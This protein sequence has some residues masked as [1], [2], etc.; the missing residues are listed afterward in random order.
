VGCGGS[1][2][3]L[4]FFLLNGVVPAEHFT[5]Y[6]RQQPVD[7]ISSGIWSEAAKKTKKRG[8]ASAVLGEFSLSRLVPFHKAV[9]SVF[10][11]RCPN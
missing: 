10:D 7:I 9:L 4:V 3:P 1:L 5:Q 11:R 6:S 8:R 2:A